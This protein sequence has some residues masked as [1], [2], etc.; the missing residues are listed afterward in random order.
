MLFRS[1]EYMNRID[2]EYDKAFILSLFVVLGVWHTP[3]SISTTFGSISAML[4]DNLQ[5]CL[6]E[7]FQL[8]SIYH[9][10]CLSTPILDEH[11]CAIHHKTGAAPAW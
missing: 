9:Y 11:V 2:N 1:W 4:Q 5:Y 10:N 7:I 8:S 6:A 3:A